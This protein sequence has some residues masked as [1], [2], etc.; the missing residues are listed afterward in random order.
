MAE[1]NRL[2]LRH[3][4]ARGPRRPIQRAGKEEKQADEADSSE[5]ED[6]RQNILTAMKD[7]HSLQAKPASDQHKISKI[8]FFNIIS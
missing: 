1:L 4:L 2:F 5:N 8:V 3:T 6:A 7:L